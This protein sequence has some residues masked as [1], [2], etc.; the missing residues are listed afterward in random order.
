MI[1]FVAAYHDLG[2]ARGPRLAMCWHMAE[3]GGTVGFL[4]RANQHGVSVHYVIEGSG[5]IVQMLP[6]DHMHSS[7]RVSDIRT[8]DDAPFTFQ[9]ETVTYGRTAARAVLGDWADISHGTFGPNHATI[10]VEVEGFAAVGPNAAQTVSI[11]SLAKELGLAAALGH[12]DFADYK[13]CPGKRF[14]W[15]A[16]GGHGPHD[17]QEVEPMGLQFRIVDN[18]PGTVAVKGTGKTLIRVDDSG[19]VSVPDGQLREVVA[20]IVLTAPT[21]YASAPAGATGWLVGNIP[22]LE[23]DH[24][25]AAMLLSADGVFTPSPLA[26]QLAAA[27][28]RINRAITTLG[29]TPT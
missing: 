15:P 23:P 3:G 7:I 1:P 17:H 10:A 2:R 12:R 26:V 4:S 9:G 28:A 20:Q 11:A 13:A 25:I 18:V 8:T 14:P 29:G 22:D 16:A 6:L 19:R 27:N 21:P 5:R 24:S